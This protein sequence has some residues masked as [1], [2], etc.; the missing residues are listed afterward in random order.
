M[1]LA[2]ALPRAVPALSAPPPAA[3]APSAS[4]SGR[5]PEIDALRG[6]ML[7]L[8]VCTH[9]PT[10]F[11]LP[12]GQPFGFVSAAEGFVL[13]S[14]YMAGMVYTRRA[15]AEGLAAMRRAFFR[16][17]LVI[18]ACQSAL[19]VFLFTV[20]ALIGLAKDE[21]AV[22]NLIGFFLRDPWAAS[23]A[24]LALLYRPPLLDILPM[25]VLF[26]FASPFVLDAALRRGWAVVV[27]ASLALWFAAQFGLGAR[28]Y[29]LADRAFGMPLPYAAMGSFDTLAWQFVWVLGLWL[30]AASVT[31]G[32]DP[33]PPLP[34]WLVGSA[35][36][37]ALVGLVWRHAVGQVPFGADTTLNL[38]F[39]KWQLG[40]LRLLDLLALLAVVVRFGPGWARRLPRLRVLETLGQAS[41][42]VFCAHLVLV[43]ALLA[44][45]GEASPRRPIWLDA[46]VFAGSFVL[47]YAVALAVQA[48]AKRAPRGGAVIR[49]TG[50]TAR[51]SLAATAGSR[52]RSCA[53]CPARTAPTAAS[54]PRRA[55]PCRHRRIRRARAS[56]RGSRSAGWL[57]R[58][59]AAAPRDSG[60]A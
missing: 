43:L 2:P 35:V 17:A 42:S 59:A 38:L 21:P 28:V 39:D 11:A 33:M 32:P 55:S 16:R 60:S 5:R 20:V 47:L 58:S 30:G 54:R 31:P 10:R 34:R 36:A 51:R 14:A 23:A 27:G 56:R 24:G 50:A 18:Y 4:T 3:V 37:A 8:M 44:L 46:L 19:L 26:M 22:E 52:R 41:L 45:L 1:P 53:D 57:R 6:L 29:D 25:Y 7:V 49:A 9:L 15:L 40:P 13:L 12:L 48:I